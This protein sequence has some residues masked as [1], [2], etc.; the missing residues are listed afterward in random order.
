MRR[1]SQPRG[2]G[3]RRSRS[4]GSELVCMHT[5][6]K[7]IRVLVVEDDSDTAEAILTLLVHWGHEVWTARDGGTG[8]DLAARFRPDVA[9]LDLSL[10]EVDGFEVARQIRQLPGGGATV[11]VAA[12]GYDSRAVRLAAGEVGFDHFLT[13]PFDLR[14]LRAILTAWGARTGMPA[15]SPPLGAGIG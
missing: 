8:I 10:P 9:L 2:T 14:T 15:D 7:S 11:L 12:T 3:P 5:N 4:P 1:S 13:K 6:P